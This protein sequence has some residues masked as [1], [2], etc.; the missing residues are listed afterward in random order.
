LALD[1]PHVL[2]KA[3]RNLLRM[4]Q[5]HTQG[6]VQADFDAWQELLDGPLEKLFAV[7]LSTSPVAIQLRQNTPFAGVLTQAERAKALSAFRASW[8]AA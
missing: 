1:P 3:R 4:R 2:R 5:A 7:L 6:R 8:Q